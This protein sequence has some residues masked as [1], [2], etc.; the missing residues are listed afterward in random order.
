MIKAE[1]KRWA[2]SIF[3]PYMNWLLKKNFSHF[4]LVNEMPIIPDKYGLVITPN[5]ISWWDGFFVEFLLTKRIN[6][7][8]FIMMLEDQL[9]RYMFFKYLGAFSINTKSA[10]SIIETSFY[11][12][13]IVSDIQNYLVF[14][15]QGEIEPFDK[16]PPSIKDGLR[17]FINDVNNTLVLPIAFKIQYYNEKYPAVIVRFG[18][19]IK[20]DLV[21]SNYDNYKKQFETNIQQLNKAAISKTFIKD[22]F[23]T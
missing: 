22:L 11:S 20:S 17:I 7:K 16:I 3:I 14:Y 15:P 23:T 4:Y 8:I 12:K 18:E 9:R 10:K 21:I 13:K 6:R 2:R 5:H 1:H 19:F